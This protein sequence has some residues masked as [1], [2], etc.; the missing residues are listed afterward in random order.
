MKKIVFSITMIAFLMLGMILLLSFKRKEEKELLI[1]SIPKEYSYWYDEE[2]AMSFSLYA[3]QKDCYIEYVD[4]NQYILSN[5]KN[6]YTL[7]NVVVEKE[8]NCKEDD[9][10][11]Y[12][13]EISTDILIPT[14]NNIEL[15]DATLIISNEQYTLKTSLGNITI[16]GKEYQLLSVNDLYGSYAYIDSELHLVGIN[17]CMKEDGFLNQVSVGTLKVP[18]WEIEKDMIYDSELSIE[19]L[20][21]DLFNK[22]IYTSPIYLD[23]KDDYYFL[24]ICYDSL[25]LVT[26]AS[27]TFTIN[28]DS[29]IID[30]FSYLAN[31]I[32][33]T[34]YP[35][36]RMIGEISY[37]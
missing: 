25:R 24:P 35:K 29:Y 10:D 21:H 33:I 14:C 11:F 9:E 6:Q 30:N 32:K 18:I 22:V 8:Y 27:I 31:V 12:R 13:Y 7:T 20:H 15:K 34:D 3:N 26:N 28:G 23:S 17:I 19:S 16:Y 4:Q 2:K 5:G 37:A 1:Y 36:T